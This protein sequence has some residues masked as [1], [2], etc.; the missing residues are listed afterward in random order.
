MQKA[1]VLSCL[2]LGLLFSSNSYA[3]F[4]VTNIDT[5]VYAG[6]DSVAYDIDNDGTSDIHFYWG[7]WPIDSYVMASIAHSDSLHISQ[8][9]VNNGNFNFTVNDSAVW[10]AETMAIWWDSLSSWPNGINTIKYVGYY[11]TLSPTDTLFGYFTVKPFRGTVPQTSMDDTLYIYNHVQSDNINTPIDPGDACFFDFAI[12]NNSSCTSCN[13]EVEALP[14]GGFAPYFFNWSNGST[15]SYIDNLC[16]GQ[17]SVTV[18]DANGCVFEDSIIIYDP[19]LSIA[20]STTGNGGCNSYIEAF[21]D[22]GTPP[23]AYSWDNGSTTSESG[24]VCEGWHVLTVTDSLGCIIVDSSFVADDTS[25]TTTITY[26]EGA[27][28]IC[29]DMPGCNGIAGIAV[30]NGTPPYTISVSNG[31]T[32]SFT[33][34]SYY[35]NF[36]CEGIHEFTVTDSSGYSFTNSVYI[37]GGVL[38][39]IQLMILNTTNP[40]CGGC[41]DGSIETTAFGGSPPYQWSIDGGAVWQPSSNF[42]A[43]GQGTYDVCVMDGN[44]CMTCESITLFFCDLTSIAT[45]N[46]LSCFE[47]CDG[48]I[49]GT[50]SNGSSPYTV[51]SNSGYVSLNGSTF[52]IDSL[53]EEEVIIL[54]TDDNNCTQYDTLQISQPDSLYFTY[55]Q[56]QIASCTACN[57]G[58]SEI[59]IFGGTPPYVV[60]WSDLGSASTDTIAVDLQGGS[61]VLCITDSNGCQFCDSV[62]VNFIDDS[63]IEGQVIEFSIY[64]NPA[65]DLF[66][67]QSSLAFNLIRIVD[68]QGKLVMELQNDYN[69]TIP[70]DVSEFEA[71]IYS[72]MI[73][74][75]QG[76]GIKK[77]IVH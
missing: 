34:N 35:I 6:N 46:N 55:T 58:I 50:I 21:V 9:A 74:S 63:G 52:T 77:L 8:N 38:S 44:G 54:V 62:T 59:E 66:V 45:S 28:G 36:L 5:S 29:G 22:G 61:G 41:W 33:N 23:Y 20:F 70:I 48:L 24:S 76:I 14:E 73:L 19:Q 43:L 26:I 67:I 57:D 42:Y 30:F 18:T 71:G 27:N 31:M 75:D 17:Y 68:S 60:D 1:F 4:T 15:F 32:D 11:K 65:D 49:N 40:T 37:P 10:I 25:L 64:P 13:G 16:S 39:P 7:G 12:E 53:C 47:T 2:F 72:I 3:Q 56:T 69:K 51:M